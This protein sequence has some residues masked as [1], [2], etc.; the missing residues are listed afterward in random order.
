MAENIFVFVVCGGKEH[1]DALR[2]S[3]SALK[4]YSSSK[5][6]VLTDLSRNRER[7]E[8]EHIVDVKTP[9]GLNH[10]EA[11][12]FLKTSILRHLPPANRY[13]YLD[14]DVIALNEGVN[15]IFRWF[16]PPVTFARDHCPLDKFSPE[17]MHCGCISR[18]AAWQKE[19]NELIEYNQRYARLPEYEENKRRLQ[20]K[21]EDLQVHTDWTY[22]FRYWLSPRKF[23]LNDEFY[24][25]KKQKLWYDK[26]GRPVLYETHDSPVLRIESAS[27]Y[28]Y[29]PDNGRWYIH[30]MDVFDRRCNHLKEG[31][32][33]EFSITVAN[34]Q[35]RHWNGG[36]FLFDEQS[37][38]FLESWHQKTM[39]IFGKKDWKTRDQGTLVATVWEQGLQS[40]PVL[41]QEFNLV[42]SY[43]H[44]DVTHHGSLKFS[45][46]GSDEII[47]PKFIH[48]LRP[49]GDERWDVWREVETRTGIKLDPE[50]DVFNALWIGSEL[51]KLELLTLH[52]FLAQ[53]HV[54]RLWT[55]QE[56]KTPLPQGIRLA[57]A[58]EIIPADKVFNYK[59]I[60]KYGH[61]KGSYAGFSDIFRYKMLY[62][63]GGWWVDMDVT[64][65][66]HI[67]TDKPYFFRPHHELQVVGNVM[68]CPKGSELMKRCY[69]EA[70]QRI[71]A[72]NTDW[73]KPIQILNDNVARLGLQEYISKKTSNDD[74]WEETSRFIWHSDPLPDEWLFIHW[75]NEEWRAKNVS[76]TNFYYRS[77][78]AK[79]LRKYGLYDMPASGK[80]KFINK[81]QHSALTRLLREM[82]N[83]EFALW[84]L[85]AMPFGLDVTCSPFNQLS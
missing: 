3:L 10:H 50:R 2:Y 47:K 34:P 37:G 60:N 4:K 75:Q 33:K 66:Q 78:L 51:S 21:F 38:N 76:K 18:F 57:D 19:L 74:W 7:I 20:K 31:I 83:P 23:H 82:L 41:P 39:L 27:G 53:G 26:Q 59:K 85:A 25:D 32:E 30:G 63:R 13:C 9:T 71:D 77:A 61:G 46:N 68:K 55:Y 48:V 43:A 35:W 36:V 5:I 62:E 84:V 72:N 11:S 79:L 28:R 81:L 16:V 12:I 54:F 52:S 14:T 58:N 1:T 69:E 70:S 15:E 56:I 29:N 44:H 22:I 40:H 65:L 67:S 64:C 49:W 73:H 8:H 17:A 6:M 80:E 45:I 24:L 42:A